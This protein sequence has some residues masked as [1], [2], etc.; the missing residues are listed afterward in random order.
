MKYEK[1]ET[2]PVNSRLVHVYKGHFQRKASFLAYA[3][4]FSSPR[5][6]ENFKRVENQNG[7]E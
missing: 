7:N 1:T 5:Y 6:F 3:G 2:F 4:T